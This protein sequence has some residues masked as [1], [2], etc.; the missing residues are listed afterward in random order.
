MCVC[1]LAMTSISAKLAVLSVFKKVTQKVC[2]INVQS[3]KHVIDK[4]KIILTNFFKTDICPT[5]SF[6]Y[7]FYLTL[8]DKAS[9]R[10]VELFKRY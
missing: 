4:Y 10:P 2:L 6:D 3:K 7:T 1:L 8:L 5:I 9:K